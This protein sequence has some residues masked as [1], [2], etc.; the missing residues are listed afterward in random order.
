[1]Y[2]ADLFL[3]KRRDRLRSSLLSACT[4]AV[5]LSLPAG[6]PAQNTA[7]V[8]GAWSSCATW[9]SPPAIYR[10][11][12]DTKTINNGVT[13]TADAN[14]STAAVVLNG[15]GAVNY[16]SGVVTDFV[17]DQGDDVSCDALYSALQSAGC[18][19]CGSYTSAAVN[20][21]VRI[22]EAEYN[23]IQSRLSAVT[24]V[25]ASASQFS[26]FIGALGG[27][28]TY[29]I[30]AS[31]TKAPATSYAAAFK[32][33]VFDGGPGS[34]AYGQNVAFKLKYNTTGNPDSG[35]ADY[36]NPGSYPKLTGT[37]YYV[38]KR[39]FTTTYSGGSS[40]MAYFAGSDGICYTHGSDT[41]WVSYAGDS[42]TLGSTSN[43]GAA[44]Q[45]I[46]TTVKQW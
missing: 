31:Q 3:F 37:Y 12:T 45:V 35:Y 20:D 10:N 34:S 1:M 43:F 13:V 27:P 28:E 2:K 30:T 23:A 14:W 26:N 15:S 38:I 46:T 21:Y 6:V 33:A 32:I 44:F 16:N 11:T 4:L 24:V 17:N 19:S 29:S 7:T 41:A 39:P 42:N 8:S 5:L 36:G 25:G 22:T 9:G 40:Y 18:A